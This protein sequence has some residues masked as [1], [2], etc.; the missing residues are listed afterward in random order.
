M[1]ETR[2]LD[3]TQVSGC[4]KTGCRSGN[5]EMTVEALKRH[6]NTECSEFEIN[7]PACRANIQRKNALNHLKTQCRVGFLCHYC[8]VHIAYKDY[9]QHRCAGKDLEDMQKIVAENKLLR[10]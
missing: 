2:F 10:D 6:L 9:E 5:T 1:I 8:K 4:T 3:Q 7:C